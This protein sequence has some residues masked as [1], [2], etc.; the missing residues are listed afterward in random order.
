MQNFKICLQAKELI[1]QSVSKDKSSSVD[2]DE[3]SEDDHDS[4]PLQSPQRPSRLDRSPLAKSPLFNHNQSVRFSPSAKPGSPSVR[5]SSERFKRR[6]LRRVRL[7]NLTSDDEQ[8]EF[9][10][11]YSRDLRSRRKKN[12]SS[13]LDNEENDDLEVE[14]KD[15]EVEDDR[16]EPSEVAEKNGR[17][18]RRSARMASYAYNHNFLEEYEPEEKEVIK[19]IRP[20]VQKSVSEDE[21]R[22]RGGLRRSSRTPK[23]ITFLDQSKVESSSEEEDV[24][25]HDDEDE[26]DQEEERGKIKI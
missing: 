6:H 21:G 5:R 20:K 23:P 10:R 7:Q 1:Y 4:R 2:E 12:Q 22:N 25:N 24:S 14:K 9:H 8:T 11:R 3:E 26:D 13:V 18:I 15:Q 16:E 17:P 19:K